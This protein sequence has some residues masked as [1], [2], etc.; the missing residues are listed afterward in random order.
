MQNKALFRTQSLL[1]MLG[2]ALLWAVCICTT[3]TIATAQSVYDNQ[4]P[5]TDTELV[6]FMKLLPQFRAWAASNKEMAHPSFVDNKADFT[7]SEAAAQWVQTRGFD[8]RR[9]FTVMGR[10]AAALYIISEGATL[11]DKKPQDMPSVTQAEIDLVQKYLAQLL[12]AG[13]DAPRL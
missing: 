4:S 11:Q 5:I 8:P 1:S 9:F 7:Y 6:S 12:E 3:P 10:S 2:M 13:S